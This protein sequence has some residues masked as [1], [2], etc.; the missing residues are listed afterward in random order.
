MAVRSLNYRKKLFIF[1][2]VIDLN[3]F[4]VFNEKNTTHGRETVLNFKDL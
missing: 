4:D 2:I 1:I 3:Y